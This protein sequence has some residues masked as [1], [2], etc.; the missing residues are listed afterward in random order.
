MIVGFILGNIGE[1]KDE[2]VAFI[3]S[4]CFVSDTR[5]I[6]NIVQAAP[7]ICLYT[8]DVT[9]ELL[10]LQPFEATPI[11]V[12][13]GFKLLAS[14]VNFF[15]E[16]TLGDTKR[17]APTEYFIIPE[18]EEEIYEDFLKQG[19]I[20]SYPTG[21]ARPVGDTSMRYKVFLG[22][23]QEDTSDEAILRAF[24][25]FN[26]HLKN[27]TLNTGTV[28]KVFKLLVPVGNEVSEII[29][30]DS[31]AMSIK[32]SYSQDT[33][34]LHNNVGTAFYFDMYTLN[35]TVSYSENHR[36]IITLQ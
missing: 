13:D 20:R 30:V 15:L 16:I 10:A 19:L 24:P 22:V 17:L 9:E 25:T 11:D 28:G 35:N 5:V 14:A 31:F 3:K 4:T 27:Y 7:G 12:P 6:T 26:V 36:H 21:T 1:Y 2:A 33:V 29:D 32:T 8:P 34:I 23:L 18:E